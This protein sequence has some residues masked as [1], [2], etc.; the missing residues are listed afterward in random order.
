MGEHSHK[1]GFTSA[2]IVHAISEPR[3]RIQRILNGN[4]DK[5]VCYLVA[6]LPVNEYSA[7]GLPLAAEA[8]PQGGAK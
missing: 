4:K 1:G 5:H 7:L 3:K 8:V 2:K 6:M